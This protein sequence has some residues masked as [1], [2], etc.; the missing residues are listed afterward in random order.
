MAPKKKKKKGTKGSCRAKARSGL[1]KPGRWSIARLE[2]LARCREANLRLAVVWVAG[3]KRVA[4][5]RPPW[6]EG[7]RKSAYVLSRKLSG[8]GTPSFKPLCL[9]V[10]PTTCLGRLMWSEESAGRVWR[11]PEGEGLAARVGPQVGCEVR[12]TC[13]WAFTTNMGVPTTWDPSN[14]WPRFLCRTP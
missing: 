11:C 14:T 8:A 1:Q 7:L 5:S 9:H 6:A 13:R 2:S 12:K 10:S 3:W 4:V